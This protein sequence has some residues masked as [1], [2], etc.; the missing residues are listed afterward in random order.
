M[1]EEKEQ[2]PDAKAEPQGK[3]SKGLVVVVLLAAVVLGGGAAAGGAVFAMR[4]A[5]GAAPP[6]PAPSA[7]EA[8]HTAV[9]VGTIVVDV[10]DVEGRAHHIK[11]ALSVEVPHEV[12]KEE[13]AGVLPR[14]RQAAIAYL[15]SLTYDD[16][17]SP[18][19]FARIQGELARRIVEAVGEKRIHAVL[20]TDFVSQ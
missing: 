8:P 16:A 20:V 5:S 11:V 17:T 10:R 19:S 9:D 6:E 13:L 1:A 3:S 15:R 2:A 18:K 12:G 14:G 4:F 7:E